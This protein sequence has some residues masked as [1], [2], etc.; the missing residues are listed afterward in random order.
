MVSADLARAVALAALPAAYLLGVLGVPALLV[1][2]F[3]VGA[4]SVF[5]DVA[6]QASLVRLV[7]RDQLVAGNSALEG[8]RS[9]A[10]IGGPALGVRW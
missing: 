10:R 6:Y 2:A 8:S 1:V 5:F 7:R 4:L 3:A 9:A